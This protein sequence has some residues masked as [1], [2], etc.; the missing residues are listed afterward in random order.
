MR[1]RP[2]TDVLDVDYV[3]GT[4]ALIGRWTFEAVG[5]LD[6]DYFFGGEM[7]DFCCRARG[8]GL[9]CVTDTRARATHDLQRSSDLREA[10]HAY[11]TLRNRFL[12]VRKHHPERRRSLYAVWGWRGL[13]AIAGSLARGRLARARALSLGLADG[14]GGHFGGRNERVL[15]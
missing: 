9:R 6:E 13:R 7:A 1:A 4:A 10:L 12:Y 14:L 15:G 2:S 8:E 5:L 11:Y 3:S